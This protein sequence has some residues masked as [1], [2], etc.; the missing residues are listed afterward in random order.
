MI[1]AELKNEWYTPACITDPLGPFDLD[2]AAPEVEHRRIAAR[3][4]TKA[5]DGLAQPWSGRV[6]LN[7]PFS[8]PLLR[9]FVHRMAQHGNGIMLIP[10]RGFD[11]AWFQ[12]DVFGKATAL[13]FVKGRLS[14]TGPCGRRGVHPPI[15]TLLVAYGE[16]NADILE[17]SGI[18]G[19]FV[20]L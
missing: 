18:E 4:Y 16:G 17:H 7:P 11:T 15:G 14:F 19:A 1:P 8:Q 5:D 2:P 20:R 12:E 13:L 3:E 6:W 10:C 9:Q